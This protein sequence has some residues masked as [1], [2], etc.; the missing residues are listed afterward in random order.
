M[1]KLEAHKVTQ[2]IEDLDPDV[3]RKAKAR[4][5]GASKTLYAC[6]GKDAAFREWRGKL[7][8]GDKLP[9][10]RFFKGKKAGLLMVI[11]EGW[12]QVKVT[13]EEA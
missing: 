3:V 13:G 9:R 7:R 1:R 5:D 12:A 4:L 8:R 6:P 11:D 2:R 10:G